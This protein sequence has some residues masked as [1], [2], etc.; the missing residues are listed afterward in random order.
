L[1][2]RCASV[3][4]ILCGMGTQ[5]PQKRGHSPLFSAHVYCGQ[6]AGWIKILLGTEVSLSLGDI[7]LDGDPAPPLLKG[8]SFPNFRPMPVMAK[9]L[10]GLRCHL[11]WRFRP[12]SRRL[13]AQWGPSSPEKRAQPHPIFGP[14]LL[15]SK[16]T[17]GGGDLLVG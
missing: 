11:V 3:Q 1:A 8:H 15:W 14:C 10:D 17:V 4:A 16:V 12:R 2:W 9:R 7:V 5:L 6:T 13:C